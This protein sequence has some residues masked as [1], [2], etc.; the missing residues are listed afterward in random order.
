[1]SPKLQYRLSKTYPPSST[2]HDVYNGKDITF[3][4]NEQGEP[5]TL[6]IGKRLADGAISGERYVRRIKRKPGTDEIQ[7]SHWDNKGKVGR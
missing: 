5:V 4:T 7:S 1:M 3:I 6:F 2:I